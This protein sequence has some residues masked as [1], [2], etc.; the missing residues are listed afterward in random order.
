MQFPV[1]TFTIQIHRS[2]SETSPARTNTGCKVSSSWPHEY[3][4]RRVAILHVGYMSQP[5]SPSFEL[6]N[7]RNLSPQINGLRLLVTQRFRSILQKSRLHVSAIER[8]LVSLPLIPKITNSLNSAYVK[9]TVHNLPQFQRLWL[10]CDFAFCK[11]SQRL[12]PTPQFTN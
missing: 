6:P 1:G 10:N 9:S 8:L 5:N 11:F 3:P 7:S 12:P 2:F 4:K